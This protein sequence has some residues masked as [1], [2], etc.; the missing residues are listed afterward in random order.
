M[1]V[2][3]FLVR[4]RQTFFSDVS[5]EVGGMIFYPLWRAPLVW[6]TTKYVFYVRREPLT[7]SKVIFS[8]IS[9]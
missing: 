6:R 5:T 2:M 4:A 7:H 1:F 3:C 9:Y 8:F